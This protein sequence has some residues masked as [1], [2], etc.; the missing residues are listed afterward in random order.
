MQSMFLCQQ[1][2]ICIKNPGTLLSASAY[3]ILVLTTGR[4]KDASSLIG[5][6]EQLL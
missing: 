2:H 5:E 3:T 4:Y 1:E 6:A